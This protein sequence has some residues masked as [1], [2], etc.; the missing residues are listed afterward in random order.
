MF[1]KIISWKG[2]GIWSNVDG[3]KYIAVN[4]IGNLFPVWFLLIIELGNNGFSKT[5][6][7]QTISQPYTYLILSVAFASSTLYLWIKRLKA[8][9]QTDE[10][11]NKKTPIG[12]IFYVLILFPIVG[13]YLS[14]KDCL[15][16]FQQGNSFSNCHRIV[17]VIYIMFLLVVIVYIYFQLKDFAELDK[18]KNSSK[19]NPPA[20][21]KSEID[22]LNN[23]L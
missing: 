2:W 23:D 3:W 1:N 9:N 21:V 4:L 12:M 14:K 5:G 11:L 17:P 6:I 13:F 19:V 20:S 7:Y 18:L 8:E 22:K 15:E 10:V 16:M